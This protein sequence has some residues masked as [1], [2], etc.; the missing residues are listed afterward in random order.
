MLLRSVG[1]S[2]LINYVILLKTLCAADKHD[3]SLSKV[4]KML[5]FPS[6]PKSK[7]NQNPTNQADSSG[8]SNF[9]SED[10][11]LASSIRVQFDLKT[12]QFPQAISVPY[13]LDPIQKTMNR[14]L[15]K[16]LDVAQIDYDSSHYEH[17]LFSLKPTNLPED[18]ITFAKPGS[19]YRRQ[20][21]FDVF[22]ALNR[23]ISDWSL[24][25][26][27]GELIPNDVDDTTMKR[28]FI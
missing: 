17:S 14:N 19:H 4:N 24:S 13:I 15:T 11:H 6:L 18:T 25:S 12:T 26:Y 7:S 28:A 27:V 10:K 3:V 21:S 22:N 16:D 2:K 23:D 9:L 1:I 5:T 20:S 8:I